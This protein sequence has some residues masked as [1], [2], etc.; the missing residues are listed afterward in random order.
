MLHGLL[1]DR[2]KGGLRLNQKSQVKGCDTWAIPA[3]R[4]DII[5]GSRMQFEPAFWRYLY[6]KQSSA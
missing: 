6:G 2:Y 3:P 1:P 5:A 4:P